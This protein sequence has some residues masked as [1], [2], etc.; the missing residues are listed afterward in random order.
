MINQVK[1]MK[2]IL[3]IIISVCLFGCKDEK[4]DVVIICEKGVCDTLTFDTSSNYF[5]KSN[6]R[7]VGFLYLDNIDSNTRVGLEQ[8]KPK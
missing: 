4:V 5:D 8:I 3:L 2:T 7:V 6:I 1:F